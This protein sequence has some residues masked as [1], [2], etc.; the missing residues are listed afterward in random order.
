MKQKI[1]FL[2][3][4]LI[5]ALF[6]S[7]NG[8]I[9]SKK[10]SQSKL[11]FVFSGKLD[12][13]NPLDPSHLK[14][15]GKISLLNLK[16]EGDFDFEILNKEPFSFR[17]TAK[18]IKIS[19]KELINLLKQLNI[20]SPYLKD[21]HGSSIIKDVTLLFK[22]NVYY[23][24][25]GL[26]EGPFLWQDQKLATKNLK[27]KFNV[28]N[29]S[30]VLTFDALYV[31]NSYIKK[32]SINL[33]NK[34]LSFKALSINSAM[35][36]ISKKIFQILPDTKNKLIVAI[37]NTRFMDVKD[38]SLIGNLKINDIELQLLDIDKNATLSLVKGNIFTDSLSVLIYTEQNR[39]PMNLSI[40]LRS[41]NITL[42]DKNVKFLFNSLNISGKNIYFRKEVK[43]LGI[44]SFFVPQISLSLNSS[45]TLVLNDNNPELSLETDVTF[46]DIITVTTNNNSVFMLNVHPLN[47]KFEDN[48]LDISNQEIDI[49][50]KDI[51]YFFSTEDIINLAAS[52]IKLENL[53]LKFNI[54][55]NKLLG[56][57]NFKI[58]NTNIVSK[59]ANADIIN[60]S[61]NIGFEDKYMTLTNGLLDGKINNN[62]IIKVS[63]SSR[64]PLMNIEQKSRDFVEN[65]YINLIASNINFKDIA[66]KNL[67][68][69]KQT[70]QKIETDYIIDSKTF[71]LKGNTYIESQNDYIGII[72]KK[73]QIKD[74]GLNQTTENKKSEPVDENEI[75]DVKF[76]DIVKRISKKYHF[77]FDEIAYESK[78]TNYFIDNLKGDLLFDK[79]TFLGI[80]GYFC[81]LTFEAGIEFLNP[82]VNAF[83]NINSV[84][85]PL[86]NLIGCFVYRAP[87]YIK[88]E[89]NIR[90]SVTTQGKT[91]KEIKNN[92][93]YD[94][95]VTIS[96]GQVLKLSNLGQKVE[97]I[98][99]ILSFVRLNPAK[100]SD[101]L[102][103]DSITGSISGDLK[104][105]D[106]KQII[107]RSS[108]LNLIV[109]GSY[110]I[111]KKILKIFGEVKKG[112]I[113]K[114]FNLQENLSKQK[115]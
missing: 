58:K 65:F 96:N 47:V 95:F 62:G 66:I 63:F 72:T 94:G 101:S 114:S 70:K 56:A 93:S 3:I 71:L 22:D 18:E 23:C 111:D 19:S 60:F 4:I 88:G 55:K 115:D 33:N 103:F 73:I 97:M 81:N 35:K 49:S 77:E 83:L 85:V 36:A 48:F 44:G 17:L 99:D 13:I 20:S 105:V 64:V 110:L 38:I 7:A 30:V 40:G 54:E 46:N 51:V 53:K 6:V 14:L 107:V 74:F 102:E 87:I 91:I 28:L 24:D 32:A 108:I 43:D 2:S 50:L 26:I 112:W 12:L 39:E 42:Q 98:L 31:G 59:Y 5:L 76:P 8:S 41:S 80:S 57:V 106:L 68:V 104:K 89:T 90:S 92:L 67:N 34:A 84:S 69:K 21:V 25:I 15:K 86:D 78:D 109:Q 61:S 100:L 45:G 9:D 52:N 113:N 11:G 79:K 82:G 37:N 16:L 27:T 29:N 1:F 75:I 10:L